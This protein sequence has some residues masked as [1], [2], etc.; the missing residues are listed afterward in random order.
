MKKW[1]WIFLAGLVIAAMATT[2]CMSTPDQAKAI[3]NKRIADLEDSL[4]K[5][6]ADQ[7]GSE[8][9]MIYRYK[10]MLVISLN[11][12]FLFDGESA[13]LRAGSTDRL[14]RV[15]NILKQEPNKIIRVVGHTAVWKST[16]WDSS[17]ELGGLRAV[18]VVRFLQNRGGISPQQLVA[19]TL[20]EYQ[21][22]ATNA[23]EVGRQRNRRVEIILMDADIFDVRDLQRI[24]R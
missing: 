8:D 3:E 7:L 16:T 18:N 13:T 11:E 20:G 14:L 17:W 19:S 22:I 2:S 1:K 6:L 10:E 24:A 5:E 15:A 21:P 12:K 9:A 4:K 23:D